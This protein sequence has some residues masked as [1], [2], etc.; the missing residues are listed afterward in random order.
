[1]RDGFHVGRT[2]A[3]LDEETLVV[4]ESVRR[5]DHGVVETVGVEVFEV[6][7][8]ALLEVGG[9]D[10]LQVF[11]QAQRTFHVFPCG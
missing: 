6:L 10:N 8:D 1:M 5:A 4:F 2:I 3:V 11:T 7:A 9:G